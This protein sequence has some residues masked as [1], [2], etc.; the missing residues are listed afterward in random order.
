M[1]LLSA[2]SSPG[3][4]RFMIKQQGGANAAVFIDPRI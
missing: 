2:I 1:S 4:M 3:H